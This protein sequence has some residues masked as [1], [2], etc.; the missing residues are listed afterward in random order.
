MNAQVFRIGITKKY[1]MP[2]LIEEPLTATL[3]EW[4]Y[5]S[6]S[7]LMSI[8]IKGFRY[9]QKELLIT[10][11]HDARYNSVEP[12]P[13]E[14]TLL[15]ITTQLFIYVPITYVYSGERSAITKKE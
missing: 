3:F 7:M 1:K 8:V 14:K 9:T 13:I 6:P 5:Y 11:I 12:A 2:L 15:R 4:C 10:L